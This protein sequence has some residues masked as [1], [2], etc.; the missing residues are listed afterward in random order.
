MVSIG[1]DKNYHLYVDLCPKNSVGI[2]YLS[3]YYCV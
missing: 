2:P 3:L 1:K